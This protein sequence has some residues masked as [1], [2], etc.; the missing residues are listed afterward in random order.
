MKLKTLA[1]FAIASVLAL[2]GTAEAAAI[3]LGTGP[4]SAFYVLESP[5]IGSRTYEIRYTYNESEPLDGWD[6][7]QVVDSY[8]SELSVQAF[9]FGSEE[10]PNWF[11]NAITWMGTTETAN[12]EDPFVPYWAQWVSGGEAGFPSATPV[13][14][15]V[16]SSGSGMSLPY[17]V[18]EPGA[19][20]ALKFG[21]FVT[22]PTVA[23]VPE[24]SALLLAFGGLA[25]LVRRRR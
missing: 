22:V 10:A 21:D 4:D 2:T 12:S 9:N 18:I 23:P 8:E 3:V 16:W 17:R 1:A 19:W 25:V 13:A 14:D 15:G 20:E 5:N 6:L 11:V 7:L 24:P